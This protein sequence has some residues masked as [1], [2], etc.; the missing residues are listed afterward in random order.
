MQTVGEQFQGTRPTLKISTNKIVSTS[1]EPS[2]PSVP[3]AIPKNKISEMGIKEMK[4]EIV[5]MTEKL[6]LKNLP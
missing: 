2:P 1:K 6:R 5:D 4:E 3:M